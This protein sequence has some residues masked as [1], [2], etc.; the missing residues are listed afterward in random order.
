MSE[1]DFAA[2]HRPVVHHPAA[3]GGPYDLDDPAGQA[4]AVHAGFIPDG[5]GRLYPMAEGRRA[6][7][8]RPRRPEGGPDAAA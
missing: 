3:G 4:A 6:R 7:L 1:P 5:R 8:G 2:H